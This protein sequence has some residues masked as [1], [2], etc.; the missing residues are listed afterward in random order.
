MSISKPEERTEPS[1][2]IISLCAPVKD[3]SPGPGMG[4]HYITQAER[5]ATH[6]SIIFMVN[7]SQGVGT[8]DPLHVQTD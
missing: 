7:V 8:A 1:G 3:D 6:D 5:T 2:I 4:L